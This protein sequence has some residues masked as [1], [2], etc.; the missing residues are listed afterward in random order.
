MSKKPEKTG[1][2][3]A[4]NADAPKK[5]SKLKLALFALV[6]L[7]LVGGGG[8]AGWAFY[9]APAGAEQ[10]EPGDEH[11][12]EGEAGHE[13]PDPVQVSAVPSEIA[14]E[15]SF[16]HSFALSVILADDCGVVPVE[17][18][19]AASDEEAKADGLLVNLS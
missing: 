19:K 13:T 9:L 18:L 6:P 5:R 14:A 2:D 15:T 17:A 8:Y 12:A 10:A 7:L 1:A 3:T 11:A 4:A 16:T